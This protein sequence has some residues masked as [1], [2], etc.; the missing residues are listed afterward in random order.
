M[1]EK[2]TKGNKSKRMVLAY[3]SAAPRVSTRMDAEASGPRA[4]ILGVD[5][6]I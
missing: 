5:A 3:L 2:S 6:V 1:V 4:H